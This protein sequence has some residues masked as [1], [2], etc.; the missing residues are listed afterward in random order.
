[1]SETYTRRLESSHADIGSS[2]RRVRF[3]ISRQ[4]DWPHPLAC[5]NELDEQFLG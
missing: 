4:E 3:G 5:G 1:M 2:V